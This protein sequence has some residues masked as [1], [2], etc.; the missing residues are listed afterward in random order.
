M[1]YKFSDKSKRILSECTTNIQTLFNEVITV[2]DCTAV[3]GRRDAEDQN[4]AFAEGTSQLKYPDSKH[5]ML[6]S[7]AIDIV[8]YI[9]GKAIFGNNEIERLNM[10]YFAGIVMGI[11]YKQ[12]EAGEID[13]KFRWGGDWNRN[14]DVGDNWRDFAHFEEVY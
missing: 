3:C 5:N 12:L 11:T 6:R 9:N 2:F 7:R 13:C 4:R 10:A 14:N 1:I 8:P